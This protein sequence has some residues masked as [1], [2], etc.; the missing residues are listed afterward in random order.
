MGRVGE[1][2]HVTN[3]VNM[4]LDL[5]YRH[6]DTVTAPSTHLRHCYNK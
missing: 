5:G 2:D 1:G 6:I 4:A 3:M